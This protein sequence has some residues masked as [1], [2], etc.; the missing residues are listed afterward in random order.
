VWNTEASWGFTPYKSIPSDRAI[1]ASWAARY[2]LL[3]WSNGI[4]RLYW[5]AWPAVGNSWGQT[6]GPP[7]RHRLPASAELDA[8]CDDAVGLHGERHRVVMPAHASGGYSALAVWD[9]R[10]S[11][12]TGAADNGSG[13][14]RLTVK[15]A[16]A[17]S[18]GDSVTVASVGGVTAAN[19]T[20]TVT[21]ASS[22]A[23]DLQGSTF[24]GTYTS[25]GAWSVNSTY[26]VPSSPNYAVYRDVNGVARQCPAIAR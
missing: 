17:L 16:N 21:V 7:R 18:T 19:G 24:S 1:Q 14:I 11:N 8:R 9:A 5:Y 4:S 26:T 3:N 13:L 6:C 10:W 22:T 25:G 2:L 20:W 15:N 12:I 23:I